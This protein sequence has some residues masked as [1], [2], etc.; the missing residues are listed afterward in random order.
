VAS[1][2]SDGA[3]LE[4][5]LIPLEAMLRQFPFRILGFHSGNGSEFINHTV[6]KLL[7]SCW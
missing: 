1:N 4:A 2:G 7:Q 6:A 3:D 5:W